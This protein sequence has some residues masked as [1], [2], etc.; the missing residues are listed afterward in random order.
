MTGKRIYYDML[1]GGKKVV[2][3]R[4]FK[5][6]LIKICRLQDSPKSVAGGFAFGT[7]VHFY[8]TCG[9]GALV[10]VVLAGLFRT[11]I[12]AATLAW[13]FTMPLFPVMFYLDFVVGHL[14]V[15]PVNCSVSP[16]VRNVSHSGWKS[17]MLLGKAF[18]IGALFNG[19]VATIILW[20]TGYIILKRYRKNILRFVCRVL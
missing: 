12:A 18:L 3:R 4:R 8:P 2:Y 10:T 13:A 1:G 5:Y 14:F 15:K 17:L 7:V 9:F 19:I 16:L 20:W 6:Y 11:N